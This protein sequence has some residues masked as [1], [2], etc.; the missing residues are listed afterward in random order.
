MTTAIHGATLIDGTGADP[1][2][3]TTIIIEEA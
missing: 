1:V 2:P 3:N